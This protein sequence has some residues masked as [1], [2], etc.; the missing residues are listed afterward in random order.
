MKK[1]SLSQINTK[2]KPLININGVNLMSETASSPPPL[3]LQCAD[4]V[5]CGLCP[6]GQSRSTSFFLYSVV[7]GICRDIL[8]Y[9]ACVIE[10]PWPLFCGFL[11]KGSWRSHRRSHRIIA[12]ST[13]GER[14]W[15]RLCAQENMWNAHIRFALLS[16]FLHC[17]KGNHLNLTLFNM[18]G[19]REILWFNCILTGEKTL[20]DLVFQ[21]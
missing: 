11:I 18:S 10:L 19:Y 16:R 17:V 9:F 21:H 15:Y 7:V 14:S 2:S 3:F 6:T 20:F 5:L 4:D 8:C 12:I 13:R 1:P